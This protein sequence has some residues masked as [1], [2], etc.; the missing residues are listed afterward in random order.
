MKKI[1]LIC[2]FT[3]AISEFL[4]AQDSVEMSHNKLNWQKSFGKAKR[5]AKTNNKPLLIYF[6][7]SDW[8][9]PCKM[10]V[11]DFFESDKFKEIADKEFVLYEA[12]T[13][14]NIDLVTESQKSDNNKLKNKYDIF[15]YPTIIIIDEN[16]KF[17]GK[18]KGYNL[19]REVDYHYAFIDSVLKKI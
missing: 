6:T 16:G 12:D 7:G 11:A 2:L 8:C 10:Q 5:I 4:N 17:L 3:V 14:R 13:P 19:M 18:I 9:G 1:L 15:S